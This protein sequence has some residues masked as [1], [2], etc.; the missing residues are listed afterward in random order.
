MLVK[1][2]TIKGVQWPLVLGMHLSEMI[3]RESLKDN[4]SG[5]KMQSLLVY[6][7][8]D[9]YC[10]CNGVVNNLSFTDCFCHVEEVLDSKDPELTKELS[11]LIASFMDSKPVREKIELA[12]ELQKKRLLGQKS[13]PTPSE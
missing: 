6:Y 8:H 4:F 7:G 2:V 3:E 13:E 11:D 1:N 12:A 9:N 5:V 10:Q